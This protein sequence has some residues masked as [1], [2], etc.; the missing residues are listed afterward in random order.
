MDGV[1]LNGSGKGGI[2]EPVQ[3]LLSHV[4]VVLYS[5][6]RTKEMC[7]EW[8]RYGDYGQSIDPK[9]LKDRSNHSGSAAMFEF[10]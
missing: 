9:S 5:I 10:R 2:H 4:A 6:L 8:D 1:V 7:S 3:P